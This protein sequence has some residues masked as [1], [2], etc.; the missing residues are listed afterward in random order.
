V[1]FPRIEQKSTLKDM[2]D[3]G[4]RP[5]AGSQQYDSDANSPNMFARSNDA[6]LSSQYS[7]S[8]PPLR[9]KP[10][11][12]QSLAPF[13]NQFDPMYHPAARYAQVP[14]QAQHQYQQ[15]DMSG[16]GNA[17]PSI[18]THAPPRPYATFDDS[19]HLASQSS[20]SGVYPPHF[21]ATAQPHAHHMN[22]AQRSF[23]QQQQ[24]QNQHLHQHQSATPLYHHTQP[25]FRLQQQPYSSYPTSLPAAAPIGHDM[26]GRAYNVFPT[27]AQPSPTAA[28]H[29]FLPAMDPR[30]VLAQAS[31]AGQIMPT[32]NNH[33][34]GKH[35]TC[36]LHVHRPALVS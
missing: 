20:Q 11:F 16:L 14:P 10:D 27:S 35:N 19:T 8:I 6:E 25:Q 17:L 29:F 5:L 1:K 28:S 15:L 3:A 13:Y 7:N 18:A 33:S 36:N 4:T 23:A 12:F 24:Q 22:S 9:G 32:F 2:G 30:F 34:H 21:G 26:H 31:S